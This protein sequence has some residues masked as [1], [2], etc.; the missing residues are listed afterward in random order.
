MVGSGYGAVSKDLS[1]LSLQ[2][3]YIFGNK[4]G[5]AAYQKKNFF[6]GATI[7]SL[8]DKIFSNDEF[9][10][11]DQFSRVSA[12][13]ETTEREVS[14]FDFKSSSPLSALVKLRSGVGFDLPY[15]NWSDVLSR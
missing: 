5:L 8:G 4:I 1:N 2:A 14:D 13:A 9:V 12:E 7:S 11:E 6:G 15:D 10:F 3:N